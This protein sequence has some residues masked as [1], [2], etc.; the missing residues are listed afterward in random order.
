MEAL[1]CSYFF[2]IQLQLGGGQGLLSRI[3][4]RFAGKVSRR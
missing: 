2:P 4:D 1:F 3:I